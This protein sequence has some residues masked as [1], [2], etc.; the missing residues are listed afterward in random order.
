[1]ALNTTV[2]ISAAS[3]SFDVSSTFCII[4]HKGCKNTGLMSYSTFLRMNLQ[5]L[6]KYR[7]YY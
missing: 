2:A 3:T 4:E 7:H 5:K 1:M 6:A